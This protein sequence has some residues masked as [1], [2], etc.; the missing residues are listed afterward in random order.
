MRDPYVLVVPAD[1]PLAAR[2]FVD[3]AQHVCAELG[4][5][6]PVAPSGRSPRRASRPASRRTDPRR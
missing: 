1:S 5:P 2:A 6:A 4:R 3:I